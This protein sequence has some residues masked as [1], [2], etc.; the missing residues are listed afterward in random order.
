MA[1]QFV[2]LNAVEPLDADR[3]KDIAARYAAKLQR[4]A[5]DEI[6]LVVDL[7]AHNKAGKRSKYTFRLALRAPTK[8]IEASA[9]DWEITRAFR[10]ACKALERETEH[11]LHSDEHRDRHR[12]KY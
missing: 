8:T 4:M 5:K 2:G 7:K 3:I 1:V 9:F 11:K 6:L 12:K 10:M